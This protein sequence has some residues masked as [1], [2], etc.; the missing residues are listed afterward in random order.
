MKDNLK[1]KHYNTIRS[2]GLESEYNK[3]F[4]KLYA[5]AFIKHTVLTNNKLK[6]YLI[7]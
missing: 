2:D 5:G 4:D 1:F 6:T 7:E 3:I